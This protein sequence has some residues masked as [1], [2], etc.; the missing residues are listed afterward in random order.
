MLELI[1]ITEVNDALAEMV[2]L[3]RVELRSY[4]GIVSKLNID[5][6]REEV[7]E[8][9]AAGF[10]VFAALVDGQYAGYVV[11]RVD[12]EVVWVES[13]F[14]KEKFRRQGVASA[15]HRKAE[16]I[17]AHFGQEKIYNVTG[18]PETTG[19]WPG[20]KLL[21][22]KRNEPEVWAKTKKIFML[23]DYLIYKIT[24]KFVT[25]K[26]L[27]SSTI[28]FDIRNSSWWS[29]MLDFIGVSQDQ[30][31]ELKGSGEYVGDYD[32][33]KVYSMLLLMGRYVNPKFKFGGDSG[34]K[35]IKSHEMCMRGYIY[36][37]YIRV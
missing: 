21:W 9:L 14:V 30:L 37:S 10:P 11:C 32:G 23:E 34:R 26:T 6:G 18:Q 8:Y 25:E 7:E 12:S 36:Q 16:E 28:Y 20:C 13:I 27:Q 33:I 19:G 2:A 29:E 24:G 3:F 15:L 4:K 22:V 17:A 31:P 1:T 35:R 5:A